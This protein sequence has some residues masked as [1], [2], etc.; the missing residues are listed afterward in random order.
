MSEPT[1]VEKIVSWKYL[2]DE[3]CDEI[4]EPIIWCSRDRHALEAPFRC[5]TG[6]PQ[7]VTF[8]AFSAHYVLFPT[9]HEGSETVGYV[10]RHP[11]VLSPEDD[12]YHTSHIGK[13]W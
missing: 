13:G 2:I 5:D 4:G 8:T 12:D 9:I 11:D 1:V 7:G 6:S 10:P 3:V